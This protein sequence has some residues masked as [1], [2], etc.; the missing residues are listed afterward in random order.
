MQAGSLELPVY[1]AGSWASQSHLF[2]A[3]N[4]LSVRVNPVAFQTMCLLG[5]PSLI[6]LVNFLCV[7]SHPLA[8]RREDLDFNL[9]EIVIHRAL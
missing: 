7:G 5:F 3:I 4:F 2:P 9:E 6:N 1:P 8:Y